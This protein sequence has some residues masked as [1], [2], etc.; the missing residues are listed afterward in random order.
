MDQNVLEER[1]IRD[2][3]RQ[4]N[5]N[6]EKSGDLRLKALHKLID[7]THTQKTSLKI[8]AAKNIPLL[9]NDFQDEEEVAINAV[10]DLCEDQEKSARRM[11]LHSIL[12]L[13]CTVVSKVA[14]KWVKRNTDVLLQLLQS[15]E[16]DEVIVV[17]QALIEHLDLDPRVTLGVLCDQLMPAETS[18]VDAD[19]LYMRDRLRTLVLAFLAGEAKEAILEG[20]ALPK[21]DGEGVLVEGLLAAIPTLTP[22]DTGVVVK[23][24]L[25]QLHSFRVGSSRSGVL[26]PVLVNKAKLCLKADVSQQRPSLATTRFYMELMAYV[27]IEKSIGSPMDLLRFYLPDLVSKGSLQRFSPSDQIFVICNMAEALAACEKGIKTSE[28]SQLSVLRNQSVEASPN[29][30]ECLAKAGMANDRSRNACRVILQSCLH[31]K[32]EGWKVPAHFRSPLETLRTKSE[33]FK[34]VQD[35]I[36]SLVSPAEASSNEVVKSKPLAGVSPKPIVQ[37][38]PPSGQRSMPG[39]SLRHALPSREIPV[40]STS[41]FNER[42]PAVNRNSYG[43]DSSP[44]PVKRARTDSDE[45]PSLLSRLATKETDHRPNVARPGRAAHQKPADTDNSTP[46]G[47]YSIKGAAKALNEPPA[48]PKASPSLLNRIIMDDDGRDGGVS[49]LRRKYP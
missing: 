2:L 11:E 10:Y 42:A 7:L 4:A 20:H 9:F 36:R 41:A 16:P 47:G 40:A 3:I 43:G 6:R 35:L 17:K 46:R 37:N 38:T 24:L 33:Q 14:N 13:I 21:S 15:D 28:P 44:R 29:L 5:A 23:Q 1:E 26:V 30:F 8:L 19:E 32:G 39:S 12:G 27:A 18:M 31:R 45:P 49:S 34:D 22:P 25:L 48:L